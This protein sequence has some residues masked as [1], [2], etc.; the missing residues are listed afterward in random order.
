MTVRENTFRIF[1]WDTDCLLD[2]VTAADAD[3][4]IDEWKDANRSLAAAITV[5]VEQVDTEALET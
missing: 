4:A 1:D 3:E 2:T 5:Y